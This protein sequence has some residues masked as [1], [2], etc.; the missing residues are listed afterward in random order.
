MLRKIYDNL[1][2]GGYFELQDPC[3]PMLSDDGTLDGTE[4]GE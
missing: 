1:E 2:P 4:L 3:L